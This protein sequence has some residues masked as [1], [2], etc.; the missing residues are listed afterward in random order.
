MNEARKIELDNA[1]KTLLRIIEETKAEKTETDQLY[2]RAL[3]SML[4]NLRVLDEAYEKES[5]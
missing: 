4:E 5:V 3:S 2:D 1:R